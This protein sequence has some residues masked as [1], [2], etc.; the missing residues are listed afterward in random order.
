MRSAYVQSVV[1]EQAAC[2]VAER[3][4]RAAQAVR[5]PVAEEVASAEHRKVTCRIDHYGSSPPHRDI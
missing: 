4:G 1:A 5:C 2:E 3:E